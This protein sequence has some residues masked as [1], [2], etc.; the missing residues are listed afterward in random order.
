MSASAGTI[1]R[2]GQLPS[3]EAARASTRGGLV[4]PVV[5]IISISLLVT[6]GLVWS[7]AQLLNRN[8]EA[9]T[10]H[11]ARSMLTN[12][13]HALRSLAIDSA[14]SDDSFNNLIGGFDRAW[15]DRNLGGYL[16]LAHDVS[17]SMVIAESNRTIVAYLGGAR[18]DMDAFQ[19]V[20]TGLRTLVER[21]RRGFL[22]TPDAV[23]GLTKIEG[24]V[25]LVAAS[26]LTSVSS[27]WAPSDAGRRPVLVLTQALDR[28]LLSR[29]GTAFALEGLDYVSGPTPPNRF[30]INLV[31]LDGVRLG[32]LAWRGPR[33][34]DGLLLWLMPSLACALG[35]VTYLLYL[36]FRSTDLVLER[37]AH[38]VSSLRRERELRNLKS[39]FVTMVSHELRTPM[40]TIRSAV[41]MLDRY[42]Q[43]LTPEER[44][45]ELGAI[46]TA[47]GGLTKMVDNV[48]AL[49][50]FDAAAK[51][52][53][54]R[55]NIEQFCRELWDE[56]QRAHNAPQRLELGG[57]AVQRTL[58]VDETFL[59]VILS[60]LFQNA[61]KYAS[62]GEK[63][64]VVV[65]AAQTD[66]IITVT[67]FGQGIP[68]EEQETIFEAFER[69]S[70]AA[71]TS[72]TGLGL[73]VAKAAAERLGGSLGVESLPGSGSTFK[74]VL[75]GTLKARPSLRRKEKT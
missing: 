7:S 26:P 74:L 17:T 65:D 25:H 48:L 8:A 34:G 69:G 21:A 49:G 20:P 45:R 72:G 56:T 6:C 10:T 36:F 27:P 63:V 29:W 68:A 35:A 58:L 39:R 75:P 57:S 66:C 2:V 51:K 5:F 43:R 38:L 67:D 16:T 55:L 28:E 1:E 24:Q 62:D 37:Q 3:S 53:E 4:S 19:Y 61:V 52:N 73:A 22:D 30:G 33:P 9:T 15:A 47:V 11:L 18:V 50:R 70:S 40:A 12:K 13:L 41:D 31:G 32:G 54:T 42:E 14:W 44:R 64:A 46:R 71:S 59:R 60:N 23:V